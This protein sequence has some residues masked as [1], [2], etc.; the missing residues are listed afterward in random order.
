VPATFIFAPMKQR[1]LP[2]LAGMLLLGSCNNQDSVSKAPPSENDLD[3]ARNF[4]R[5]SLDRDWERA[6][7]Y[8]LRDS[9][10]L[11]RL[12]RIESFYGNEDKLERRNYRDAQITTYDSRKV[13]DSVTIVPYSN[14]YKNKRDSVKVVRINGEW[15]VDLKFSFLPTD[16]TT[17]TR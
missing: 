2:F 10:N 13:N 14:T 8:M 3:A 11:E 16:S 9:S 17:N 4:I 6:K 15:L 5:A 12:D 7:V 1:F